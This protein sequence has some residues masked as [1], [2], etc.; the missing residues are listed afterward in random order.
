MSSNHVDAP[1]L[2]VQ[3]ELTNPQPHQ[4]VLLQDIILKWLD[5]LIHQ[6]LIH[7]HSKLAPL[8]TWYPLYEDLRV[9]SC[10]ESY[11]QKARRAIEDGTNSKSPCPTIL[12]A[13]NN[14][15]GVK[16]KTTN[17]AIIRTYYQLTL[18]HQIR[19]L[20]IATFCL[21]AWEI[22]TPRK[23]VGDKAGREKWALSLIHI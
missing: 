22:E 2:E 14:L 21:A 6:G 11:V 10:L 9:P 1:L 5:S 12:T 3:Y 17:E 23:V 20:T 13:L 15:I 8:N 18:P 19:V 4:H 7:P 16:S